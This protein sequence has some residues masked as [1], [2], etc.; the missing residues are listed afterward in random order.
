MVDIITLKEESIRNIIWFPQAGG[1]IG[2]IASIIQYLPS[3]IGLFYVRYRKPKET[4]DSECTFDELVANVAKQLQTF[5]NTF[6]IGCSLGGYIAYHVAH[7]LGQTLKSENVKK[8]ILISVESY[9][10]LPIHVSIEELKAQFRKVIRVDDV[11]LQEYIFE[12]I[13]NDMSLLNSLKDFSG[14]TILQPLIILHGEQDELIQ[15]D[16]FAEEF[17]ETKT[18]DIYTVYEYKGGHL[19]NHTDLMKIVKKLLLNE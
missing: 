16:C 14:K 4:F 6:Y 10:A 17:W 19:P 11:Q 9:N 13:L 8:V 7:L 18:R 1:Y 2:Q 5:K 12:E 3:D 15:W